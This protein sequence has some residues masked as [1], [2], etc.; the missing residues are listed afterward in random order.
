MIPFKNISFL[1]K[2]PLIFPSAI[3]L[4]LLNSCNVIQY[5]PEDEK[6]YTGANV[7]VESVPPGSVKGENQVKYEIEKVVEPSPNKKI[8]GMRYGLYAHFKS[9]EEGAGKLWQ[10]LNKRFGEEPVYLSQ[11][12]RKRS[13]TIIENRC[14]NTGFFYPEISSSI[15]EKDR[16]ASVDYLVKIGRPYVLE[17]YIFNPDSVETPI[18]PIIRESL[19]ETELEKGVRFDTDLFKKERQRIDE[20][21]KNRGYYEFNSEYLIFTADTNQYDERKFDLYLSFKDVAPPAALRRY[22]IQDVDVYPDFS[23]NDSSTATADTVTVRKVDFVQ[24]KMIFRPDRLRPFITFEPGDFYDKKN[25]DKTSRRLSSIGAFSLVSIRYDRVDTGYTDSTGQLQAR[26]LLTPA[27]RQSVRLELQGV[28]KSNSFAGPGLTGSYQN[29]NLFRGGERLNISGTISYET[30]IANGSA[31]NL[32]SFEFKLQNSISFPRLIA[33]FTINPQRGFTIPSTKFS[34]NYTF[35]RRAQFYNLNSFLF[36][37]G[38]F[39]KS[40]RFLYYE[41]N[42]VSLNY[43]RTSNETADFQDILN[44]N[45]FLARSFEDQFILGPTGTMQYSELGE[46]DKKNRFYINVDGEIAALALGQTQNLLNDERQLFGLPYAQY[47]K[48]GVDF[49]H[50]LS[51]FR[52]SQLVSRVFAG[53]GFPYGNSLSLPFVKQ[54]FS[55]G[56]S[57]VRAFRIRSLGPGSYNPP[58]TG[59][60][61]FF[62][63]SGD[64]KLE[65]NVEFRHPLVSL[66]KG[67]VFLDAGNIWLMNE[68]PAVPGGQ[69]SSTWAQE[70]AIGTGYGFRLDIDFLVIRLDISIPLRYPTEVNGSH[71][72]NQFAFGQK[73]WR[74]E[75]L[76]WNFAIGYPF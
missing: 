8:F 44:N 52:E 24:Q 63:Q 38:Y 71:W 76:V 53:A 13:E 49:R 36:S 21:L 28:T 40:N 20:I 73:D 48:T 17:T 39:W 66:L 60:T 47:F 45:P 62:D 6:L 70:L 65:A 54:Y 27:P 3:L 29:K 4:F 51:L 33:P 34:L 10:N 41:V 72:Q 50:Y 12:N 46:A 7:E 64:I 30:Q 25:T 68:N 16:T 18:N 69:F 43:T 19:S 59:S 31:K 58:D 42:P 22:N 75:N 23:L 15:N 67:A 55:G 1:L 61:S 57:S 9:Q 2:N 14:E 32:S 26:V 74:Q 56:P 5:I 37:Y 11:V 35:Q